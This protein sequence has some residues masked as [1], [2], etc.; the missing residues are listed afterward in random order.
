[1]SV[2]AAV[3]SINNAAPVGVDAI[4]NRANA[5]NEQI[6]KLQKHFR[7]EA[8]GMF[9]NFVSE[10]FKTYPKVNAFAWTQYTPHYNDGEECTFRVNDYGM[11]YGF[12]PEAFEELEFEANDLGWGSDVIANEEGTAEMVIGE[13]MSATYNAWRAYRDEQLKKPKAALDK[14]FAALGDDVFLSLFDNHVLVIVT[15]DGVDVQEYDHD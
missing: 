8:K 4:L 2:E 7:E 3:N 15:R 9:A 14:L 12:T 5:L 6:A 10:F 11:V 1:M 13:Y